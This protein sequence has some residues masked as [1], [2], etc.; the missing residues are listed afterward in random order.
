MS[1]RY[2]NG[3][4]VVEYT[5][6]ERAELVRKA[7]LRFKMKA[8]GAKG[9]A[10]QALARKVD[11]ALATARATGTLPNGIRFVAVR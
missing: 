8:L 1:I 11:A 5:P 4:R 6:A 2:V 3:V 10:A 9:N 7:E